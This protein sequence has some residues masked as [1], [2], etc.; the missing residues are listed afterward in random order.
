[1]KGNAMQETPRQY[2][3]RILGY[4]KGKTPL[5]VLASTPAKLARLLRGVSRKRLMKRPA[6]ATWS[7]AEVL[8]HL[9]DAELVVAYR[10]RLMLGNNG[11]GIQAYNQAEWARCLQYG[12]QDPMDSLETFRA[13]RA[14]N[15]RMLRKLSKR[16]WG[17]YGMHSERGKE[18]VKR[19]AEMTAGHDINHMSQ[20]ERIVRRRKT[21]E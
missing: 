5:A 6:S 16:M 10:F 11:T 21:Q 13:C 4:Q 8:A 9:A 14:H 2:T 1:V 12:K 7:I 15:I 18:T 17:Y 3:K 19:L 20:I